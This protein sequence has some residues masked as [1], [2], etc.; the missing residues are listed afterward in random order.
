MLERY[1]LFGAA[2][3]MENLCR[4][5]V[6]SRDR[7]QPYFNLLHDLDINEVQRAQLRGWAQMILAE[8]NV[9]LGD[10]DGP[11]AD[12]INELKEIFEKME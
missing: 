1:K 6:M 3:R 2:R 4:I 12:H 11:L 5:K 7:F 10:E 8:G 9:I